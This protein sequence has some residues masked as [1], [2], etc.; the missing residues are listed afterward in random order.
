ML[1]I[2]NTVHKNDIVV[3]FNVYASMLQGCVKME[4]LPEGYVQS[5]ICEEALKLFVEMEENG[6]QPNEFT[7]ATVVKACAN[8]EDIEI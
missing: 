2:F 1:S 3:D 8:L 5:G 4:A 6:V 7:F